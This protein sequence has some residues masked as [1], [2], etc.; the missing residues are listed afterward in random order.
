MKVADLWR[1]PVKSMIGER[2]EVAGIGALGMVGDRTW[3]VRDEERGGIRGA[4]KIGGLM[5]LAAHYRDEVGGAVE[6]T[7]PGGATTS[8]LDDDV[9]ERISGALG[10]RVTLCPLRPATDR[11][12]YRRGGPDFPDIMDELRDMFG[13]TVDEPL[14]DLSRFP[15]ELAEFESPPGTYV[16]AYPLHLVSTSALAAIS[17]AVPGSAFNVRRLRPDV[18]IYMGV[19]AGQPEVDWVSRALQIGDTRLKVIDT[20]PRCVMVTRRI[21]D[22]TPEDRAILRHV[23]RDLDQAVGIY[24]TVERDGT[25]KVGDE[26]ELLVD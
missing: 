8:S 6:I 3:A 22:E 14:P 24:A 5:Q 12:H 19:S 18:A 20:C 21:D 10:H 25:I 23:V 7:L 1:H 11:D 2:V 9:D 26:V 13:R 4:K 15:A 16:D 17:A